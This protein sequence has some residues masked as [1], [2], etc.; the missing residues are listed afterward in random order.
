MTKTRSDGINTLLCILVPIQIM[1]VYG[2]FSESTE[3]FLL[4]L[5]NT[6]ATLAHLHYGCC[7]VS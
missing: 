4:Y 5:Y 1:A 6:I 7:V 2:L 3:F